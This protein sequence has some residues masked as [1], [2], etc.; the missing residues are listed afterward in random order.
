MVVEDPHQEISEENI[1]LNKKFISNSDIVVVSRVPF[2]KKNYEN[3]LS[4]EEALNLNKKVYFIDGS[5]FSSRDYTNGRATELFK[6]ILKKG[7]VSV[8]N[9]EELAILL[10]KGGA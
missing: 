9:E 3:L 2:G 1:K 8:D 10:K 4:V 5:N 7:A 6:K